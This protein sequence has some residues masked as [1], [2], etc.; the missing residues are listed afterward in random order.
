VIKLEIAKES[1][2]TLAKYPHC[3]RLVKLAVQ[4]HDCFEVR[5]AL[6]TK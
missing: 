6:E 3:G 2:I 4:P 5:H 1:A